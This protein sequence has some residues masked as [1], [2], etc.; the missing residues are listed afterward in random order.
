[1]SRD[2][3]DAFI[4]GYV[5]DM[6]IPTSVKNILGDKNGEI[7]NA[8]IIDIIENSKNSDVVGFSDSTYEVVT[9]LKR[10]NYKNIYNHPSLR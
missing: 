8:M 5:S 6:D 9:E 1:M 3:E 10:F 7:I 2:Q 4:A